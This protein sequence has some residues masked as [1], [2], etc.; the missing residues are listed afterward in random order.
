MDKKALL[1]EIDQGVA[2][3]TLNLPE[4]RNALSLEIRLGLVDILRKLGEEEV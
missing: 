2:K 4:V 1:L 3:I